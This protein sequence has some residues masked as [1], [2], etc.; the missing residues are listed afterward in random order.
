MCSALGR[1]AF[2]ARRVKCGASPSMIGTSSNQPAPNDKAASG[3][4]FTD[5][6]RSPL[7]GPPAIPSS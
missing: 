7:E 1:F 6:R 5:R 4:Q 2:R 3:T